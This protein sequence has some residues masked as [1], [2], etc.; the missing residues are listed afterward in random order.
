MR[1]KKKISILNKTIITCLK[2]SKYDNRF[3]GVYRDSNF[4]LR[5]NYPWRIVLSAIYGHLCRGSKF[6]TRCDGNKAIIL[7]LR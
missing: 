4:G 2:K 5:R 1:R 7:A 6:L 3:L